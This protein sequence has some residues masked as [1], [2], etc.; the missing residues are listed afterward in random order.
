MN[1]KKVLI[2]SQAQKGFE[3]SF[4]DIITLLYLFLP[5]FLKAT[6]KTS[7]DKTKGVFLKKPFIKE[8]CVKME[9]SLKAQKKSNSQI[10]KILTLLSK[11]KLGTNLDSLTDLVSLL[12]VTYYKTLEEKEKKVFYAFY[13]IYTEEDL[14]ENALIVIKKFV[15]WLPDKR[16][17]LL[18]RSIKHKS[19]DKPIQIKDLNKKVFGTETPS[20]KMLKKLSKSPKKYKAWRKTLTE[21]NRSAKLILEDYWKD[22]ELEIVSVKTAHSILKKLKLPDPIDEEY[23]GKVGLG[24]T[25]ATLFKYYTQN[26]LEL[27]NN[28][29]VQVEMN[30]K[31]KEGSRVRGEGFYCTALPAGSFT[32]NK[33]R[34]Y[35]INYRIETN[36]NHFVSV[37]KVGEVIED[38]RDQISKDINSKKEDKRLSALISRL[39]D[40]VYSRVGNPI[41][42]KEG[43][44]GLHNLYGKHVKIINDK[45]YLK[46][47][48]K[49]KQN[50]SK[51]ITNPETVKILKNLK[52]KAGNKGY[53][54]A[55]KNGKSVS[56]TI[57]NSYLKEIGFPGTIHLFRHYHA[58]RIFAEEVRKFKIEKKGKKLGNRTV[59]LKFNNI[60]DNKV[61]KALGNKRAACLK[62]Y[63]DPNLVV[64]Y[65]KYFNVEQPKS[66]KAYIKICLEENK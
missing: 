44:F 7:Y 8:I 10:R 47:V 41:S 34:L 63:I 42:E 3:P 6:F 57:I 54:F 53:L 9:E 58:T 13:K 45:L 20:I 28:P 66:V 62:H 11:S 12:K 32:N 48:G 64:E 15:N 2:Q 18:L 33:V 35:T 1:M 21:S 40:Q 27:V 55:K 36:G 25:P 37:V 17:R 5:S 16:F 29:G 14:K 65:F 46:Y 31:Y 38:V 22:R 52:K 59:L 56:P 30:P 39:A 24:D 49:D 19:L 51:L 61:A 50:Q 60:V 43:I 23:V 26:G 4:L